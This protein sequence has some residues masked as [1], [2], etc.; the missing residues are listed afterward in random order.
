MHAQPSLTA[1][2][3]VTIIAFIGGKAG[4]HGFLAS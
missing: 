4:T 2:T 1:E 3:V